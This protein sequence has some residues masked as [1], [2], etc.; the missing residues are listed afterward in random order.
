MCVIPGAFNGGQETESGQR[1]S[2][3]TCQRHVSIHVPFGQGWFENWDGRSVSDVT[4][5]LPAKTLRS[6][7]PH[8][9]R[10]E[11]QRKSWV[12]DYAHHKAIIAIYLYLLYFLSLFQCQRKSKQTVN[13]KAMD[14]KII[15][16]HFLF[17]WLTAVQREKEKMIINK[18]EKE[19]HPPSAAAAL[20]LSLSRCIYC[21]LFPANLSRFK[22]H[23]GL[24]P[25]S[26]SLMKNLFCR[27]TKSSMP[28]LIWFYGV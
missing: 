28:L 24:P 15:S 23:L 20:L 7:A 21:N 27:T 4:W 17:P 26:L 2:W 12:G 13:H 16:S 11:L 6:A 10:A 25:P 19:N 9:P 22:G 18:K 1:R 14:Y 5:P 8:S 3:R